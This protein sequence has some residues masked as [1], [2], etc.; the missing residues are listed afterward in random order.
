MARF[1][2]DTEVVALQSPMSAVTFFSLLVI[3]SHWEWVTTA[4]TFACL[5]AIFALLFSI[6]IFILVWLLLWNFKFNAE[7]EQRVM[8]FYY[9]IRVTNDAD[10]ELDYIVWL[11][12]SNWLIRLELESYF[13]VR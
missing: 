3:E 4:R 2:I 6:P 5:W 13:K 8:K 7:G 1:V 9:V 10:I 11:V 12:H